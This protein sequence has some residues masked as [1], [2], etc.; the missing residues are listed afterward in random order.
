MTIRLTSLVA[1]I[2]RSRSVASIWSSL[3]SRFI[4]AL[5]ILRAIIGTSDVYGTVQVVDGYP[6]Q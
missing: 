4:Y 2:S 3:R 6:V 5:P 1:K